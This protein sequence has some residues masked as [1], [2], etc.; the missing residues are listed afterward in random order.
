[1]NTRILVVAV[2]ASGWISISPVHAIEPNEV[3]PVWPG[4]P[5][6]QVVNRKELITVKNDV[7]REC[8]FQ[9]EPEQ[10]TTAIV[11]HHPNAKYFN[12]TRYANCAP[13]E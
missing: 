1:M 6:G 8:Q 10:S 13:T 7:E 9:L 12:T 3:F 2:F 5:P 11:V 4:K